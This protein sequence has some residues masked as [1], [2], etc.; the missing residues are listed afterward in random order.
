MTTLRRL[1]IFGAFVAIASTPLFASAFAG[2]G[3]G[4][5]LTEEEAAQRATD[6]YQE[7]SQAYANGEFER[8]ADLLNRAFAH[9]ADLIY[10]YNQVMALMGVGDYDR[11]LKLLAEHE[12]SL[13]DDER[14]DDIAELRTEL[15]DYLAARE[16]Q[17]RR[18]EEQRAQREQEQ[19]AQ[20]QAALEEDMDAPFEEEESNSL[21]WGLAGSGAATL[22]TGLFFGSGILVSDH[23]E[24]I[25]GS[26]TPD[27]E[28]AVYDDVSFDRDDDLSTLRTHRVLSAVFLSSGVILTATGGV[29]LKRGS[30]SESGTGEGLTL[31]L[32]PTLSTDRVGA[33]L[34]GRF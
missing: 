20:E 8:A 19:Q 22:A 16:E 32:K 27:D 4:E 15:E 23:I 9:D 1:F 29:L 2:D 5:E 28:R 11:A 6:Y 17:E 10:L 25:E 3:P 13:L 14:F 30:D 12:Q 21:G 34:R 24:R 31:R 33:V 7:A 26:R 18:A